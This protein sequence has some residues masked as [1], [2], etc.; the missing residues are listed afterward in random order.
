ME[1][2]SRGEY[3]DARRQIQ[4]TNYGTTRW[5]TFAKREMRKHTPIV[6]P[7]SSGQ[8]GPGRGPV[9]R[10]N[11]FHGGGPAHGNGEPFRAV[12]KAIQALRSESVDRTV[13]RA[14]PPPPPSF[15]RR[16][17]SVWWVP[18]EKWEWKSRSNQSSAIPNLNTNLLNI[19]LRRGFIITLYIS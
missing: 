6:N 7:Y 15:P 18:R 1:G 16:R 10:W 11:S 14:Q 2:N 4:G 12:P 3:L 13:Q 19:F 17:F 5:T 8:S 9:R